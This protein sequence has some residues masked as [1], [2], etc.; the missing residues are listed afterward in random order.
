MIEV[1]LNGKR[2]TTD[3]TGWTTDDRYLGALL[4]HYASPQAV[5]GDEPPGYRY[6]PDMA[7]TMA[8][9]AEEKIPELKIITKHASLDHSIIY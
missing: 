4:R 3:G 1:E 6:I 9:L 5:W 7:M 2:A 8:R